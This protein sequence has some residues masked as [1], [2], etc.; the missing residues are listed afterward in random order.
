M[1]P[2]AEQAERLGVVLEEGMTPNDLRTLG[3][4][5]PGFYPPNSVLSRDDESTPSNPL[6]V[7]RFGRTTGWHWKLYVGSTAKFL[8]EEQPELKLSLEDQE[9]LL[10]VLVRDLDV[11]FTEIPD[12]T[13]EDILDMIEAYVLLPW[14]TYCPDVSTSSSDEMKKK[15]AEIVRSFPV[16]RKEDVPSTQTEDLAKG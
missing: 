16:I 14:T 10:R 15:Y 13:E 5:I 6:Y 8:W 12:L 4:E 11:M 1:I 7:S 2:I 3:I 9:Y